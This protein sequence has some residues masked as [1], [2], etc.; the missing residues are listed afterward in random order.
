MK[1]ILF[2]LLFSIVALLS[3]GQ[4]QYR[5]DFRTTM[6][7]YGDTSSLQS[8]RNMK[9][10]YLYDKNDVSGRIDMFNESIWITYYDEN[11]IKRTTSISIPNNRITDYS[12][13]GSKL[14]LE[15]NNGQIHVEIDG[16]SV[17]VSKKVGSRIYVWWGSIN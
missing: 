11:D 12:E 16:S 14:D 2:T 4:T 10:I 15:Y 5:I 9:S 17:V 7:R 1:R 3:F 8:L 6:Y 13:S